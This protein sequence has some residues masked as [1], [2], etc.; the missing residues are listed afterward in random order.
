MLIVT[1]A[2][3]LVYLFLSQPK[4]GNAPTGIQLDKIKKSPHYRDGKFHNLNYT[5]DLTEG[6]TYFKIL[7]KVLFEKNKR[8]R[9]Q[10]VLPSKI[11]N[12]HALDPS[13][14]VIVWFGHSSY[15]LQIDGKRFL[16][17]PVFSGAASPVKATTR[18]FAGTD[19]YSADDIPAIDILF[20]SHDHW[21]HLDYETILKLKPKIGM[22][23]CGLGTGAH[24]RKWGFDV[25]K[26]NELD[27]NESVSLEDGFSVTA[28]PARHFS[29][30]SLIR[31]RAIWVSFVLQTRNRKLFLGGDSGYD[32]HF[33]TIGSV[34]GPFDLVILECGQYDESWKYIH[35]MPEETVQAASDLQAK[36]LM[37]VH[38]AKFALGNHAWDD[39]ILRV[40]RSAQQV[41]M[42]L[43]TP[44]I[45]QKLLLDE[46][47]LINDWWKGVN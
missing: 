12:L 44:M 30:R 46:Q 45:G 27:W 9:P 41:N 26:I 28:T 40:T 35:L 18:S 14:D 23:I 11:T 1:V 15:F 13:E 43:F 47:P 5:P 25:A 22:I 36:V 4:F 39:S 32:T 3:L 8:S 10:D 16:V 21:D 2:I 6:T 38:W 33:K 20:I 17:D 19:V 37:P 31:N 42:P 7:K 24:L 29:G 34:H